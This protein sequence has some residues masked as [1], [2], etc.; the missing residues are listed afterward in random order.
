MSC[1]PTFKILKV[2]TLS[3]CRLNQAWK[4]PAWG[5]KATVKILPLRGGCNFLPPDIS[6]VPV[7]NQVVWRVVRPAA[8]LGDLSTGST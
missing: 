2:A 5:K 4:F 3:I 8:D 7:A 6:R 1:D